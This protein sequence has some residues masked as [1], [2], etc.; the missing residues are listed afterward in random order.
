MVITKVNNWLAD[1]VA[2]LFSHMGTAYAFLILSLLP[3]VFPGA[4]A[5]ILYI[6]NAIQLDALAL[7][8]V[9]GAVSSAVVMKLLRDIHVEVMETLEEL[10]SHHDDLRIHLG[11]KLPSTEEV[12]G[13]SQ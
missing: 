5:A 8:G 12:A 6:S 3:L 2:F 11:M 10:K 13:S 4:M 1:K 7:L 9:S